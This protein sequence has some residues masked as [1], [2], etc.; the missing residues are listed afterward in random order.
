MRA[1]NWISS[2]VHEFGRGAGIGALPLHARGAA[3][4]RFENGIMLRFEYME[5]ALVVATSIGARDDASTA[6]RIL[7]FAHPDA[8]FGV[9][10][11]AGYLARSGS[12]FFAVRLAEQE[13]TLPVLGAAFD[14]L[15]RVAKE[16]G[17]V[18]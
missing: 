4:I 14:A 15:W 1:P 11:R 5:G 16:F 9:T 7:S 6:R 8:R 12:A 2:A 18:S 10:V 13:V 17:G 3:A